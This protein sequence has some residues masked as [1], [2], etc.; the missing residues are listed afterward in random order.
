M[1]ISSAPTACW[2]ALPMAGATEIIGCSPTP[3]APYGPSSWGVSTTMH[4]ISV[5]EVLRGRDLV[6]G[7][8]RVEQVALLVVDVALAQRGA[9]A[10]DHAADALAAHESRVD[11]LPT[12]YDRGDLQDVELAGVRVDVDDDAV[13]AVRPVERRAAP[14]RSPCRG[15][16]R[17]CAT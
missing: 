16:D 12:S 17:P 15:C 7:E 1:C 3:R 11:H 5:G 13:G 6:V 2:I 4:S 9:E 14:A 10:L 8:R